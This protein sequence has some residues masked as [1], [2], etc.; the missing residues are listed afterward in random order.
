MSMNA[1]LAEH[2]GTGKT[3]EVQTAQDDLEKQ[4]SVELFCKL[5][6][7][8]GLD[9]NSLSDEQVQGLYDGWLN[10]AAEEEKEKDEEKKK[11]EKAEAEHEEKKESAAKFAEADFLGR[12]MAHAFTDES[13][14]IAWS[15]K[16]LG[17][18]AVEGAKGL[19]KSWLSHVKGENV[20]AAKQL[21]RGQLERLYEAGGRHPKG[22]P[23]AETGKMLLKERAKRV[24]A[25]GAPVA[26][27][28]AAGA[29]GVHHAT[30]KESSALDE[31]AFS[32]AAE[33]AASGGFDPAEAQSKIAAAFTLDLVE[34]SMKVASA[35]D[36]PTA[37]DIRALELLE[38]VGY[39]IT[40]NQ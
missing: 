18:R 12:V 5:A 14:K 2:Y 22:A 23:A 3:A 13:E 33:L 31:F 28:G 6:S 38:R 20:E 26:A 25:I 17:T 10:K 9:L 1:F 30:K 40:W 34:D 37:V 32:R 35:P 24:A 39:P 11:V 7:E 16:E 19:G 27:V 21:H 15:A 8:E 4:A 29:A 36:L